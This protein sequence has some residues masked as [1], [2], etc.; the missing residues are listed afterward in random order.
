M[1]ILDSMDIG[2]ICVMAYPEAMKDEVK[3]LDAVKKIA[4]DTYFKAI[5]I[6][7]INDTEIKKE[8]MEIITSSKLRMAFSGHSLLLANNL[9]INSLDEEERIKAV[10]KLKEG[11][12]EA[13]EMNAESFSFLS[14]DY[15]ED[16][17]EKYLFSLIK[18]TIELCEYSKSKG[19]MPIIHE[20]F[21][22]DI[23]KKSLIGPT[24][25]AKEYA[26]RVTKLCDNFGLMV[27]LS[28][29]PLL[30][31]NIDS[32][33]EPI[34]QY[35]KHAHMGNAVVR[36]GLPGYGD[37]HPRFGFEN[38]SND[39]K[40][41]EEYLKKLSEIGFLNKT[42]KPIVSFEVKPFEDELSEIVIVNA[43][44]TLNEA[45]VNINK[46]EIEMNNSIKQYMDVGIVHFM[47]YP[48]TIK[49]EGP[50]LE[51]VKTI[52]VDDYFDAIEVTW[53]KD[54]EVRAKAAKM[55]ND[56]K[57]KLR[58][59][60]QPRLLT[61]GLN[62]NAIN[63][64]DRQL[65]EKTL[66]EAI[67]EAEEMGAPGIAF[68]SGKYEDETM[69]EAYAQLVKTTKNMCTYA[70]A[71]NMSI[72]LEVF[73]YDIAKK[74]LVGPTSLAKRFA[75]EI[76]KDHDNFGLLVDLSHIPMYYESLMESIDPIKDYIVH[77]HMGNTVIKDPEMAGY[78]DEHIRFGFENSE[79]DT[80]ELRD[81]LQHCINTGVISKE[82]KKVVS[83]EVKPYGDEDVDI[84]IANA[85]RT[86]NQ[87]WSQVKL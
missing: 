11:I 64:E 16:K 31:E 81:F 65:A 14:R 82:N 9:N 6:G 57:L 66:L 1:K 73:D 77:L 79:N 71:K 56:S 44:R 19:D 27:D 7:H 37:Q 40:E 50:I 78:G 60:A 86:L 61:T 47:A 84:V 68:L 10:S 32:S 87:A 30:G 45:L 25:R 53:M 83:F 12:D 42:N 70:K 51:T 58:Y 49:G 46:G 52:A 72:V 20:I 21:D 34:K 5:E 2:L 22:C 69:E 67:D 59:G 55:I 75:E 76:N 74:A 8:V 4:K 23:D 80:N 13:Y 15:E 26:K 63:E 24:L 17:V 41:L 39:T 35:I 38:S 85:K 36:E 3:L 62:P 54:P 28:H 29:F 18:S 43:K 33:I 48:A